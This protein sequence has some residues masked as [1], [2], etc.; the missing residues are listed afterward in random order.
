[1]KEIN[2]DQNWQDRLDQGKPLSSSEVEPGLRAYQLLYEALEQ[3]P[4]V[5][6]PADFAERV[7]Q[8]AVNQSS[9]KSVSYW[10]L[11]V[12]VVVVATL[13][14]GSILSVIYP[15]YFQL[16]RSQLDILGFA[17][18]MFIAIQAADY[19]LVQRKLLTKSQPITAR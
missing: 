17:G 9:Q 2:K 4:D 11:A 12:I 14:C 6:I 3:K 5:T 16:L 18:L 8:Q 15:T 13:V 10:V 19:Y 7:A 1:M